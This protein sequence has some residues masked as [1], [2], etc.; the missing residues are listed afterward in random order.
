[1]SG[2]KAGPLA[3]N[4]LAA[5]SQVA[6]QLVVTF[7]LYAV[8][9][10]QLGAA[11]VGIW[12]SV[13]AATLLACCAD[14]GLTYALI[15]AT[16]VAEAG[17]RRGELLDLVDTTM[18]SVAVGMAISLGLMLAVADWLL[19]FSNISPGQRAIAI[20]LAPFAAAVTWLQRCGEVYAACLEGTLRYW[21]LARNWA[22]GYVT[23][24]T[25]TLATVPFLGLRA[26]AYA[27]TVQFLLILVLNIRS[28]RAVIPGLRF[29]PVTW[30]R[31]LFGE[32]LRYGAAVQLIVFSFVILEV[33]AKLVLALMGALIFVTYFDISFR[34]GRSMR[35][36][37]NAGSRVVVPLIAAAE[38]G[39]DHER[40][41]LYRLS[42]RAIALIAAPAFGLL[43]AMS[44]A[45]GVAMTGRWSN[46][47]VFTSAWLF[48]AWGLLA[49]AIPAQN[50]CLGTG[51]LRWVVASH[52]LMLASGIGSAVVFASRGPEAVVAA[53]AASMALGS[54]IMVL[55]YH[56]TERVP[57]R[58]LDWKR[59]GGMLA[60]GLL[61]GAGGLALT[62]YLHDAVSIA[63]WPAAVGSLAAAIL[64]A[65][66]WCHPDRG[67]LLASL[68]AMRR[69]S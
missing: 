24:F 62:S 38:R 37:I 57:F 66:A 13:M 60:A 40:E 10:R 3:G 20:E 23:G 25:L 27:M 45:L 22:I 28:S 51:R 30:N 55:S 8:L 34:L 67:R 47:F 59:N 32:Q 41:R 54:L 17:Q 69:G 48:T 43:A 14:L 64:L 44:G 58:A 7:L 16:A 6:V 1:M 11:D 21:T 2:S 50:G 5:S 19:A 39:A 4:A 35:G 26:V 12:L 56:L 68:R 15:R 9:I 52:L 46:G 49:L 65:A 53:L 63:V 33:G 61:S 36:L 31:R 18:L 29:P 42:F